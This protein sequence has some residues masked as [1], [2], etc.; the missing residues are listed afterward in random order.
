V[1]E[2]VVIT[3]DLPAGLKYHSHE[4]V[5]T[6]AASAGNL[7]AN[8]AGSFQTTPPTLAQPG[9]DVTWSFGDVT[10]TADNNPANNSFL[11]KVVALVLN[12]STPLNLAGSALTNSAKLDYK[13]AADQP[14]TV[15]GGEQTVNVVEPQITTVKKVNPLTGVQ[16]GDKVMY[17][18]TFE[19]TGGS[20][21]YDVTAE[22]I[23]AQGVAYTTVPSA[24]QCKDNNNVTFPTS[25]TV[26]NGGT[27][28]QLSGTPGNPWNLVV[29]NKLTCTYYV[30][31]L[32]NLIIGVDHVNVVDADWTSQPGTGP[33]NEERKYDDSN[34]AYLVDGDQD[35]DDAVFTTTPTYES[36]CLT[37]VAGYERTM[38]YGRGMGNK[39]TGQSLVQIS[40][41]DPNNVVELYAQYSGKY[42]GMPKKVRFFTTKQPAI[43]QTVPV[44]YAYRAHA[45]YWY[46]TDLQVPVPWVKVRVWDTILARERT[47]RAAVI[48]PTYK[49][50]ELTY[51]AWEL[52]DD[53]TKNHVYWEPTWYQTQVFRLPIATPV[54]A[55]DI[56]VQAAVVE[57][58]K[59]NRPF[60]LTIEAGGV[61]VFTSQVAPN[62]GDML[63]LINVTLP[64]V[65][66]GT[67]EV[68][69]TLHSPST[70]AQLL[71]GGDSVSLMGVAVNYSCVP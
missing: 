31:A 52:L 41:P 54:Q 29:G 62:K 45:V 58:D 36:V 23:L 8:F 60:E 12:D 43:D 64:N 7:T 19:N 26:T 9:G 44:S 50:S 61:S 30:N 38:M 18:V 33:A 5:T 3:D 28:L 1:T 55:T 69:F 48:Y 56:V 14:K 71:L 40:V 34:P 68:V 57:N 46:G 49:T 63:N 2:D 42:V 35:E 15:P 67:S 27:R 59:D 17:T 70:S 6:V 11:V 65:P 39:K 24:I 66:A 13:D 22:D 32:F 10:T 16:P 4:I 20:T 53:S 51:N 25:V 21:A 47:P 37:G